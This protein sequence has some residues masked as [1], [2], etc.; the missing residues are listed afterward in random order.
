MLDSLDFETYRHR[1]DA[2]P[3]ERGHRRRPSSGIAITNPVQGTVVDVS[4]AGIGLECE[5]PLRVRDRYPFTLAMDPD[6]RTHRSGEVRWCRMMATNDEETGESTLV[7]RI[8]IALD[9]P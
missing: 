5:R 7:F 6:L 1:L 9:K 3:D 8:G 4:S 2:E